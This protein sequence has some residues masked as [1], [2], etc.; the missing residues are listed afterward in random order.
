MRTSLLILFVFPV[1]LL[2][3]F[4]RAETVT[5]AATAPAITQ[6][7]DEPGR[8]P[9]QVH[10]AQP[11]NCDPI[12]C[13][14]TF[15]TITASERVVVENVNCVVYVSQGASYVLPTLGG[16]AQNPSLI[17]YFSPTPSGS[18]SGLDMYIVNSQTQFYFG[19][20]DKPS[21]TLQMVGNAVSPAIDCT[22]HGYRVLLP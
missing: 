6:D 14:V 13:V 10:S 5:T 15:P 18:V 11:S 16:I 3:S 21:V 22:L 9:Y 20:G 19:K 17:A 1:L 7:R 8:N 2:T 4:A 12:K